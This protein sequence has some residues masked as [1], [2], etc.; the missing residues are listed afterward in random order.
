EEF[1]H[2]FN[3]LHESN[4]QVVL[5]SDRPPKAIT[6]LEDR[7]RSRFEWGLIADVQA[8]D[9]ET[10]MA[11][12]RAKGEGQAVRV[13]AEVVEFLARKVQSNIRELEGSLNRLVALALLNNQKITIEFAASALTELAEDPRRRTLTT[14]KVVQ[15]VADH[16]RV[17]IRDLR[18]KQRDK[19]IVLPRQVAMYL[20]REETD[21]SLV[22]IGRELGG[23]DHSTVLHGCEKIGSEI[24]ANNTLRRDVLAIREALYAEGS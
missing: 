9:Y 1:F 21:A 5:S 8:P 11:I 14:L 19:A 6:T 18:G 2:T 13:P 10:R 23:R 24:N 3:A 22:E 12:L 4:R 7:L 16:F 20:M 17:D 15:A